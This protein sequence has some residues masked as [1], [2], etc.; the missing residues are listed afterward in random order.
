MPKPCFWAINRNGQVHYLI[1][2][3]MEWKLLIPN[4]SR[5]SFKKISAQEHC[6]WAI[7]A[8]QRIYMCVFPTDI[9]IRAKVSTFENQRWS[10]TKGW[11]DKAM[12][13]TD[14]PA[15]SSE[16]GRTPL[17]KSS[18]TLE[19]HWKWEDEWFRD[20]SSE[21]DDE[22]WQYAIDFPRRYSRTKRKLSFVR[23]SKWSRYKSYDG[24]G[25]WIRIQWEE[26]RKDPFQDI[27]VGGSLLPRQPTGYLSVWALTFCGKLLYRD[28]IAQSCPEGTQW[29]RIDGCEDFNLTQVSVGPSGLLWAIQWDGTPIVRI[30]IS[31]E[32]PIGRFWQK[33]GLPSKCPPTFQFAHVSVG[34]GAVWALGR[35]DKV[36][37]RKGIDGVQA[38]TNE[39][40]ACGCNWI[41]M[42]GDFKLI[43]VGPN[44]QVWAIDK[45][46]AVFVRTDITQNEPVGRK[47]KL[48]KASPGLSGVDMTVLAE[49]L[50][51]WIWI[52]SGGCNVDAMFLKNPPKRS[53]RLPRES[54]EPWR[55]KTLEFLKQRNESEINRYKTFNR[56]IESENPNLWSKSAKCHMLSNKELNLW[57]EC[58][59]KFQTEEDPSRNAVL[60][61]YSTRDDF[62]EIRVPLKEI[63][64]V[65][66]SVIPSHPNTF[67]VN[68]LERTHRRNPLIVSMDSE[69]EANEWITLISLEAAK[70]RLSHP[71]RKPTRNSVWA[72]T[73]SGDVF[74]CP[75][76]TW[77]GFAL[78]AMFWMQVGG[79]MKYVTAGVDGVVWGI[80]FDGTA[81]AYSGGEGGGIF[82]GQ[83]FSDEEIYEQE[84]SEDI[85]IY[86]NQRWNPYEGFTDRL[87]PSDRWA[88]SNKS[89]TYQCPRNGYQLPSSQWRWDGD[90]EYVYKKGKTDDNGWQYAV[91]FPARYHSSR[92]VHDFVR[93]RKWKRK[94]R[95]K[96]TGPWLLVESDMK[97]ADVAIQ[98]DPGDTVAYCIAVWAVGTNGYVYYRDS[99]HAAHPTGHS[100]RF[101]SATVKFVSISIGS[102]RKVWGIA[103]DGSA[104]LRAGFGSD[105]LIGTQWFRCE[106]SRIPLRRISVGSDAVLALDSE[107]KLWRRKEI[108]PTFPEGTQWMYIGDGFS[109]VTMGFRNDTWI[110]RSNDVEVCI[111]RDT[112]NPIG[113]GVICVLAGD[114][115]TVCIRGCT[116]EVVEADEVI[117]QDLSHS[118]SIPGVVASTLIEDISDV[119]KSTDIY[120]QNSVYSDLEESDSLTE[121]SNS[122]EEGS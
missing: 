111:G 84:D 117:E 67:V 43:S 79:H 98:T 75:R 69:N 121:E 24:F 90:W 40:S 112:E 102:H 72:T 55:T 36:F 18:F 50:T 35:N 107:G 26:D 95:L 33:I 10:V 74:F 116:P 5:Q 39:N 17:L 99:V 66:R 38:Y 113:S 30:G 16:D 49:G 71:L 61:Y 44:D 42:V 76:S 80:G 110:V 21:F 23:R 8:D 82:E 47:W 41:D 3:D 53:V 12:I 103:E 2:P 59:V 91:D 78:D 22:G 105:A 83:G 108:T 58:H 57:C 34:M 88:W 54:R 37:Y 122:N 29:I 119:F 19:P 87:L 7:G 65:N 104:Y 94:C 52:N 97:L 118:F 89:G 31:H 114:W 68:T 115:R 46:G 85:F 4:V 6:A 70:I 73:V 77:E 28:G 25:K 20:L 15:W 45:S 92:N 100:W 56:V 86:E 1:L 14:R 48:F 13:V 63:S 93:R 96:T 81:Y 106:G 9:P 64:C 51:Q 62:S 120:S 60:F 11:S 32:N 27:T 109:H 101:I